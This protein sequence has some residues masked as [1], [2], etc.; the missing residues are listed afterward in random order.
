MQNESITTQSN[1]NPVHDGVLVISGY[2]ISI[3]IEDGFLVI[4][5]GIGYNRRSLTFSKVTS[6]IQAW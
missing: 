2:G 3:N 1:N 4:H 6:K 5:D